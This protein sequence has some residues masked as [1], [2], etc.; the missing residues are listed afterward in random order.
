MHVSQF[1]PLYPVA[2]TEQVVPDHPNAQVAQDIPF[3]QEL[4][5]GLMVMHAKQI[6]ALEK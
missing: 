2:Q 1:V 3:V 5:W 4:Q 6:P